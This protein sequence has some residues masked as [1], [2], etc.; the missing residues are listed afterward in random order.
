MEARV[1]GGCL[2]PLN[3]NFSSTAPKFSSFRRHC[4]YVTSN[5]VL[6]MVISVYIVHVYKD[7]N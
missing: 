6:K 7:V 5:Q 1:D 4:Q 2:L 3:T